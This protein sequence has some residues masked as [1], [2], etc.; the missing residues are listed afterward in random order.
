VK[1]VRYNRA[2]LSSTGR[3]AQ[4]LAAADGRP[5]YVFATAYGFTIDLQPAPF[6]RPYIAV[7]PDGSSTLIDRAL[8]GGQ[9]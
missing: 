5:R 7:A 2:D 3:A 8:K 4:K 1:G 9:R 6:G